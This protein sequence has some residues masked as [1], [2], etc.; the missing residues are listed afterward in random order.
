MATSCNAQKK[1]KNEQKAHI[2]QDELILSMDSNAE[3][4]VIESGVS[5]HATSNRKVLQNYVAGD[6]GK[7]YLANDEP[8]DI[9][10][11]VM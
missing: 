6:L 8:C 3:S 4:W 9:M 7:V 10:G 2:V 1:E 11:K 5:F